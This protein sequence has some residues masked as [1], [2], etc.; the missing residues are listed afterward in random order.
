M[1]YPEIT[2][3]FVGVLKVSAPYLNLTMNIVIRTEKFVEPITGIIN[4]LHVVFYSEYFRYHF[5]NSL[6]DDIYYFF[7]AVPNTLDAL[8]PVCN[9]QSE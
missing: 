2:D 7:P 1:P 3:I 9:K 8:P 6:I 5:I 4:L